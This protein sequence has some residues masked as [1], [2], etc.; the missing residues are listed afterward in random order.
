MNFNGEMVF[1][2]ADDNPIEESVRE[3][4][5]NS[6]ISREEIGMLKNWRNFYRR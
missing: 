1:D 4:V 2:I 5:R 3:A 6:G